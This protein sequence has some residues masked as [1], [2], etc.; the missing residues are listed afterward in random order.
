[1]SKIGK[2]RR[3]AGSTPDHAHKTVS[4]SPCT[5]ELEEHLFLYDLEGAAT[6]G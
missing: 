5:Q 6:P 2:R 1:M 3:T 4:E